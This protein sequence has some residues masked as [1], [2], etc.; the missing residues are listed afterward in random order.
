M[1]AAWFERCVDFSTDLLLLVA[2]MVRPRPIF[3]NLQTL[4]CTLSCGGRVTLDSKIPS[5]R[6]RIYGNR[7]FVALALIC[8]FRWQQ[9]QRP[10][11]QNKRFSRL[12]AFNEHNSRPHVGLK[13]LKTVL[14]H[15]SLRVSKEISRL[16]QTSDPFAIVKAFG[17]NSFIL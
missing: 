13:L 2:T 4:P 7:I 16:L 11:P 14:T 9:N 3:R 1:V 5:P 10:Q 12:V 17:D 15:R 6:R 8:R